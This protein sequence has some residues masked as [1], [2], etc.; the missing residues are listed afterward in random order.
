MHADNGP[1]S[2]AIDRLFPVDG[3][4]HTARVLGIEKRSVDRMQS[5]YSS[6]PPRIVQKLERQV[7]LKS[8]FEAGL[9]AL[10]LSAEG[11]GL[12]PL[13]ARYSLMD[14][15]KSGRFDGEHEPL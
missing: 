14:A 11:A 8:E 3:T 9:E 1:I 13:V 6:T 10:L 5:G 2:R 4:A 7:A 12:H 15:I